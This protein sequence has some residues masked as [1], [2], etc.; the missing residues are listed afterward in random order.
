MFSN[1]HIAIIDDF[2]KME[3]FSNKVSRYNLKKQ[4]KGH[5]EEVRQFM[6]CIKEGTPAPISF[7]DIYLSTFV[8]FKVLESI[9]TNNTISIGN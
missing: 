8:T 9:K 6:H 7:E 1:G 4:D 3:F 5:S 2:K